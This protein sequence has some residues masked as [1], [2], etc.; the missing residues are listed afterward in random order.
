MRAMCTDAV[1]SADK[2]CK[3]DE[4]KSGKRR[5]STSSSNN[6]NQFD[7]IQLQ[8]QEEVERTSGIEEE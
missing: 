5:P 4:V 7:H 3:D 1:D 6:N 8:D 2:K